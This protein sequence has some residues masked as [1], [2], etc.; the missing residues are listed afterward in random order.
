[1]TAARIVE[2]RRPAYQPGPLQP[3]TAEQ[4]RFWQLLRRARPELYRGRG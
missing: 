4:A 2:N 1:M 3:M